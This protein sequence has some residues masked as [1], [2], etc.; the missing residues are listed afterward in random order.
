MTRST[1]T[2]REAASG[3]L[4]SLWR[5]FWTP[6]RPKDVLEGDSLPDESSFFVKAFP[7]VSIAIWVAVF[8]TYPAQVLPDRDLRE[9]LSHMLDDPSAEEVR[10]MSD[11]LERKRA[12]FHPQT[13]DSLHG[14]QI[15][16]F[17]GRDIHLVCLFRAGEHVRIA[18]DEIWITSLRMDRFSILAPET[19]AISVFPSYEINAARAICDQMHNA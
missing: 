9:T 3:R 11:V 1:R 19:A 13:G 4:L 17:G 15:G 14:L 6:E 18:R 5:A 7:I 8:F 10:D 12:T 2:M 16:E